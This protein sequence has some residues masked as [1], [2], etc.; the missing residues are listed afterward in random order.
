MKSATFIAVLFL[1]FTNAF[2]S[3]SETFVCDMRDLSVNDVT[4]GL[5][6]LQVSA[7]EAVLSAGVFGNTNVATLSPTNSAGTS[8]TVFL[9]NDSDGRI[10]H[11]FDLLPSGQA[12]ILIWRSYD[13]RTPSSRIPLN[14]SVHICNKK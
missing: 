6:K 13:W 5:Y 3:T 7:T 12:G 8:S 11:S 1:G 2:A 4:T 14:K 10:V 9:D